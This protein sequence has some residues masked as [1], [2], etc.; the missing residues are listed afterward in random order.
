MLLP[1]GKRKSLVDAIVNRLKSSKD[2]EG[3]Y[4]TDISRNFVEIKVLAS[5]VRIL[6]RE[7]GDE[8]ASIC[9]QTVWN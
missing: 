5:V 6:A 4:F 3:R 8:L 7:S 1:F 9:N 2:D